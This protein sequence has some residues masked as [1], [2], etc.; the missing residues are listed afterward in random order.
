MIAWA[1][2]K[3]FPNPVGHS[4]LVLI[5][6]LTPDESP[7]SIFLFFLGPIAA[8]AVKFASLCRTSSNSA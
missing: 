8:R 3:D 1:L 6:Q 7:G 4:N 5:G 2:V